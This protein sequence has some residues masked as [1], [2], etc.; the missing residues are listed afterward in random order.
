MVQTVMVVQR[1]DDES[2][3][4]LP[5]TQT[6]GAVARAYRV[7]AACAAMQEIDA[8]QTK[9]SD[10][11]VRVVKEGAVPVK[12]MAFIS[13]DLFVLSHPLNKLCEGLSD[14]RSKDDAAAK[15]AKA[16]ASIVV[17]VLREQLRRRGTNSVAKLG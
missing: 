14:Q 15:K 3:V 6:K 17:Q 5:T 7:A 16:D 10:G 11:V 8:A 2:I 9:A 12:T 1:L 4:A 13:H